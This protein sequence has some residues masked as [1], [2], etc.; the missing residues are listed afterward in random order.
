MIFKPICVSE[1]VH[2]HYRDFRCKDSV[3]HH[4]V[5]VNN[6]NYTFGLASFETMEEFLEHFD[7]KPIVAG[8]SGEK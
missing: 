7:K 5:T 2:V 3:R 4:N 1:K 8:E 6:G